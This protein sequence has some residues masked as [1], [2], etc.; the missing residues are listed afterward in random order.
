METNKLYCVK[1][2]KFTETKDVKTKAIV[3]CFKVF[4][5]FVEQKSLNL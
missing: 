3:K 1:F 5:L 2:H 4:V